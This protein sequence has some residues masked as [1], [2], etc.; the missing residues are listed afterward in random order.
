MPQFQCEKCLKI[1]NHR[2]HFENHNK[3]KFSCLAVDD[4][5]KNGKVL[6]R[7]IP[8]AGDGNVLNIDPP[9][10]ARKGGVDINQ[11]NQQPSVAK[12]SDK[13]KILANRKML[14]TIA[15]SIPITILP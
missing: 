7:G 6:P 1:F 5:H 12:K 4:Y 8:R 15:L 10:I 14:T 3:R 2:G 9:Q 11:C 13:K